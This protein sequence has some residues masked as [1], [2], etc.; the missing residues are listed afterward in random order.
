M[1]CKT[2]WTWHKRRGVGRTKR[3][4]C[5]KCGREFDSKDGLFHC[6]DCWDNDTTAPEYMPPVRR[7]PSRSLLAAAH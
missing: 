3:R 1:K 2:T 7:D 5:L 6:D 4:T